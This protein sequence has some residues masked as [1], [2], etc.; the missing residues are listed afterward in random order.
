MNDLVEPEV[1]D[2]FREFA[3]GNPSP[4]EVRTALDRLV[5]AL[6]DARGLSAS[7]A[8]SIV[9]H[10]YPLLWNEMTKEVSVMTT[11]EEVNEK[12]DARVRAYCAARN[13]DVVK[14]YKQALDAVLA[15][16]ADLKTA[17]AGS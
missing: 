10:E 16:D 7:E 14:D 9:K 15:A 3:A 17:Y 13:L 11:R 5:R 12:V 1:R 6:I 4:S 8:W 2:W